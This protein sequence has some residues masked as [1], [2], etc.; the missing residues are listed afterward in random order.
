M[1]KME[2]V[3]AVNNV[4]CIHFRPRI[5]SDEYYISFYDGFGC[6]S[7]VNKNN[8]FLYNLILILS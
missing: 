6:S 2:R 8:H 7:Y 4:V 3:I 1:R 5:P